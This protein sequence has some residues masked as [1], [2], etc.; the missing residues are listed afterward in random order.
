MVVGIKPSGLLY[1]VI[2]SDSWRARGRPSSLSWPRVLALSLPHVIVVFMNLCLTMALASAPQPSHVLPKRCLSDG[3]ASP[4]L[5]H[6]LNNAFGSVIRP[7]AGVVEPP[8]P[9]PVTKHNKAWRA[10]FTFEVWMQRTSESTT[11]IKRSFPKTLL[12]R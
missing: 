8:A 12:E 3:P 1:R 2:R 4:T 6:H 11:K 9:K 7:V 10:A 5:A